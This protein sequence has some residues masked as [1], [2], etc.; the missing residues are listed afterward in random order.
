MENSPAVKNLGKGQERSSTNPAP[1]T[2]P[3]K[4]PT[5]TKKIFLTVYFILNPLVRVYILY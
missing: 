3:V 4:K 1:N 2:E 5:I